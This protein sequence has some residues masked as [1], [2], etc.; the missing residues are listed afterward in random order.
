MERKFLIDYA[1]SLSQFEKL[2]KQFHIK[3]IFYKNISK[4]LEFDSYKNYGPDDDARD[5]DW[6]ASVR[7]NEL[8]MKQYVEE[9]DMN[10]YFVVDVSNTMMFGSDRKLKTEYAAEIIL[11][12]SHLMLEIN[13]NVS[14]IM[15]SDRDI[16]FLGPSKGKMQFAA[17]L[18]NLYNMK[19]YGGSFDFNKMIH[20]VMLK[21]KSPFS[22]IIFLSDFIHVH[23][24][25]EKDLRLLSSKFETIAIMVHDNLDEDLDKLPQQMIIQHPFLQKQMIIDPEVTAEK[26]KEYALMQKKFVRNLFLKSH[27]D[28]IE[29]H[30]DKSFVIPLVSFLKSR[31]SKVVGR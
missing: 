15:F 16:K 13:D 18:S 28:F 30:T 12:L 17:F 26:Y 27:I 14:L 3:K 4:G 5:I 21:V 29:F 24:E 6:K 19:N 23:S 31:V 7:A 1:E 8:L 11:T 22:V 25:C 10:I 20:S 9:R 2:V